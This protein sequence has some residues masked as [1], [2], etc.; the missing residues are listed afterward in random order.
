MGKNK[1]GPKRTTAT[2]T[3]N[4]TSSS[5]SKTDANSQSSVPVDN[6]NAASSSSNC[7]NTV[8]DSVKLQQGSSKQSRS[9]VEA[10][11]APF[12]KNLDHNAKLYADYTSLSGVVLEKGQ[13]GNI[14]TRSPVPIVGRNAAAEMVAKMEKTKP[15]PPNQSQPTSKT[16]EN[17]TKN[18]DEGLLNTLGP[19]STS[20]QKLATLIQSANMALNKT[21]GFDLKK[22]EQKVSDAESETKKKLRQLTESAAASASA[23]VTSSKA[24]SHCEGGHEIVCRQCTEIQPPSL[25][26]LIKYQSS[27][28]EMFRYVR[29][30]PLK[31]DRI[32]VQHEN[33]KKNN[34]KTGR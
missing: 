2:S 11:I 31:V 28:F 14:N 26:Q 32:V 29:F 13:S 27:S 21:K 12:L 9:S 33:F 8:P 20:E 5:T 4:N 19:D 1:R 30:R 7:T 15:P 34:I 3:Q 24:V 23:G 17:A 25:M 16:K 22:Y 10:R 6:S 18:T